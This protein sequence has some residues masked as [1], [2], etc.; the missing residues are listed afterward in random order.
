MPTT[1][2]NWPTPVATDLV[3]D[4]WEAIK[5]LGDAIDTTLGVYAPSTPGLTLINTT[6]FS[7]VSSQSFNDVFNA[8]YENYRIVCYFE[9]S[10]ATTVTVRLRVGGA[11]N[12]T[13]SS[14]I[15]QQLIGSSASA[16]AARQVGSGWLE[17]VYTNAS[18]EIN[19]F[20][21]D[22][23][24]PFLATQTGGQSQGGRDNVFILQQLRHNQ[25]TSYDGFSIIASAGN[26]VN[27]KASIYGYNL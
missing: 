10:T 4:G 20:T 21:M 3:K 14:Y 2:N 6:S 15:A 26:F 13:A 23:Q 9:S 16:S 5:D 18:S 25:S 24:K 8:T 19:S 11:D 27:G 7:A 17:F 12:S 22:L 1:N